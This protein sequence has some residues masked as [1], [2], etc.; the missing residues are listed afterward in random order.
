MKARLP[1]HSNNILS[2]VQPKFARAEKIMKDTWIEFRNAVSSSSYCY[3]K[4]ENALELK[5][6]NRFDEM[7]RNVGRDRLPVSLSHCFNDYIVGRGAVLDSD[8]KLSY[9]RFIPN[10]KYIKD[11]NR[12]SP[13][14]IE[15][16]YLA[17]GKTNNLVIKCSERECKAKNN[18]RFGFC[19]FELLSQYE[20]L[21][22]ID[23]TIADNKSYDTINNIL[24]SEYER[25][26]DKRIKNI[27]KNGYGLSKFMSNENDISSSEIEKWFL[28]T[29]CKMMSEKI[30]EPVKISN[31]KE[32]YK[33]FQILAKYFEEQGY[34]GIKYKSTVCE[35]A[36]NIVLFNKD[37]AKP[38]GD[39]LD[40]NIHNKL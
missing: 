9:S 21:E 39:I 37:Y 10:K 33:P 31:K 14:G 12:F 40:Y 5:F 8:E 22:I 32:E 6:L 24:Y 4:I 19:N 15:W 11:D 25:V 38:F 16:L 28:L 34:V 17:I 23:L 18:D 35:K 2:L 29:Y 13:P 20:D 30:F 27:L 26:Y 36:N 7:F 3:D 1:K